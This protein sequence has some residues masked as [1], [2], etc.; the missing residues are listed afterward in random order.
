MFLPLVIHLNRPGF[1]SSLWFCVLSPKQFFTGRPPSMADTETGIGDKQSWS[2]VAVLPFPSENRGLFLSTHGHI[3]CK[4]NLQKRCRR[5]DLNPWPWVWLKGRDI[6]ALDR[7][8]T[9]APSLSFLLLLT[10]YGVSNFS[11]FW[12]CKNAYTRCHFYCLIDF[13]SINIFQF[14]CQYVSNI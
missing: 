3:I 7:S 9:T 2:I 11:Y 10:Y 5:L 6:D 1:L 13:L 8:T 14:W 12:C 4:I